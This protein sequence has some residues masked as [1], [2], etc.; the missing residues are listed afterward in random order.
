MKRQ[1][2]GRNVLALAAV[3][4]LALVGA[5]PASAASGPAASTTATGSAD[6]GWHTSWTQSQ[7]RISGKNF[8]NT[9]MRIITRLTQGGDRVRIRIQN[10]WG[11]GDVTV[12]KTAVALSAGGP[13]I[14]AGTN[15]V[16]TFGGNQSLTLAPGEEVWS[17]PISMQ[18]TA[19]QEL[20]VTFF[21]A[22]NPTLSLHDLA[23]R[24]NYVAPN[25][26]GDKL[27]ELSGASYNAGDMHYTY[28]VSAVDVYNEDLAGTIVAYGSSVVDGVGS[29]N[30]SG[31]STCFGQDLRWT[32]DLARRVSGRVG[33]AQYAVVNEGISGTTS[34]PRCSSDDLDGMARLD[35]DVLALSGVAGVIFYYG[36]NDVANGCSANTILA[37]YRS[38][39]TQLRDAGVKIFV[40]PITPRPGYNA[41]QNQHRATV[42]AWVRQGGDCSGWCDGVV[43]FDAV[44]QDPANANSINPAYDNG[45]GIHA[46]V[47]GQQAIADAIDL[48][49][50]ASAS[51]PAIT[52][53]APGGTVVGTPY[54]FTVQ[55]SGHPAPT[56]AVTD[57]ALPAGLGLDAVTGEISGVARA[58]VPSTFTVTASNGSGPAASKTVT[59]YVSSRPVGPT[60]TA[61]AA[62]AAALGA[63][64]S[65]TVRAGGFPAPTLAVTG[66]ALPAGLSLDPL[67]GVVSG[68]PSAV[69]TSSVTITASNG[70]GADATAT[71][72]VKVG[73]A[74]SST[75]VRVHGTVRY[76]QAARATVTVSGAGSTA[77][78][79]RVT[80][81]SGAKV[82][83]TGTLSGGR[84]GEAAVDLTVPA[85]ALAPG[86]HP[87]TVA[88]AGDARTAASRAVVTLSIGKATA[89]VTAKAPKKLH[90]GKRA[91]VK[92]V[93]K[94]P[95]AGTP[96]GKV[97]VY[98]GKRKVGTAKLS[99]K[100]KATVKTK[101]LA[102]GKHRLQVRYLGSAL[103]AKAVSAKVKVAA[104]R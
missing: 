92:A 43:D 33:G 83:A 34:S 13:A 9:S 12:D 46:N 27:D 63:P 18:T 50:L 72:V 94:A 93:V 76:G 70:V 71:L 8:S 31:P 89:T 45:D 56:F 74:S 96:S 90:A 44:L 29:D 75:T 66:G 85:T 101:A 80:L 100:G 79:G 54:S 6:D 78:T 22:G 19:Q 77:P 25:G 65:F 48:D 68:T 23:G 52:S 20:T 84:A 55:A 73:P 38:I 21:L 15:Q 40:T 62:P 59:I 41:T 17:D 57:G 69:G 26:S 47:A 1:V 11:N 53:G 87:L 28:L 35:R 60:I 32:D 14:V 37:S 98:D 10:E 7:Q 49:L 95:G 4:A 104:R 30:C 5:V 86:Q 16:L 3:A 36:T 42:N 67:T 81:S 39:F 64:Y 2:C 91:K 51:A 102:A 82:L 61:G 88:Y 103:V 97:A 58:A 99:K 24:D